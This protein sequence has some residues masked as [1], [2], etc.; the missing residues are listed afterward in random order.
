MADLSVSDDSALMVMGAVE[1]VQS[2]HATVEVEVA[3]CGTE[4]RGLVDR[5]ER[6]AVADSFEGVF[7]SFRVYESVARLVF[8]AS[9]MR[10]ELMLRAMER[11]AMASPVTGKRRRLSGRGGLVTS[12]VP[13]EWVAAARED[14]ASFYRARWKE[15]EGGGQLVLASLAADA[16]VSGLARMFLDALD[17]VVGDRGAD[18]AQLAMYA[19]TRAEMVEALGTGA[20]SP[21]D[22]LRLVEVTHDPEHDAAWDALQ[23]GSAPLSDFVESRVAL[24]ASRLAPFVVFPVSNTRPSRAQLEEAMGALRRRV[25]SDPA[26]AVARFAVFVVRAVKV[27]S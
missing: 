2:R 25:Q 13:A 21:P 20:D 7:V 16:D 11:V 5:T 19:R 26:K 6:A 8:R 10:L 18:A 27:V 24:V 3:L 17:A 4:P 1:T 14:L 15:L 23:R 22:R 9:S 12:P